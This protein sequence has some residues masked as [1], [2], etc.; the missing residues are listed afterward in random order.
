MLHDKNAQM[1]L[2]VFFH[3]NKLDIIQSW[4]H[5]PNHESNELKLTPFKKKMLVVSRTQLLPPEILG[6][7]YFHGKIFAVKERKS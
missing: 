3:S 4:Y 1:I 7:K 6:L 2:F 5:N